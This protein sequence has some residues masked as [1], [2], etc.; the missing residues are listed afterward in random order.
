MSKLYDD[1]MSDRVAIMPPRWV[2][3]ADPDIIPK[4]R[5]LVKSLLKDATVFEIT[6]VSDYYWGGTSQEWFDPRTDFG[7]VRA[8]FSNFWME[9]R[10]P[11]RIRS[12]SGRNADPNR[13]PDRTG[14]LGYVLDMKSPGVMKFTARCVGTEQKVF[15]RETDAH[16]S[17]TFVVEKTD[18]EIVDAV[19]CL[20]LRSFVDRNGVVMGPMNH[21]YVWVRAD[22]SVIDY[23]TQIEVAPGHPG[24]FKD[25]TAGF[26]NLIHP[27]MMAID[28]MHARN[29]RIVD[30]Q[31]PPKLAKANLKRTGVPTVSWKTIVI[32]P[33]SERKLL[34]EDAQTQTGTGSRP[35]QIVPGHYAHYGVVGPGGW[36]RGKLFGRVSGRF[37]IPEH[38]AGNE[39]AGIVVKDYKMADPETEPPE[40]KTHRRKKHG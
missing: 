1:I 22:G 17:D 28:M 6:N 19:E 10:R 30:V 9:A 24:P 39:A 37:W 35:W 15:A 32:L 23:V 33:F 18:A 34:T 11:S 29:A 3:E 7:C 14:V 21:F 16:K 12:E 2:A 38:E 31:P 20:H 36:L 8:P 4:G 40:K 25:E 26:E 13:L 5:K 27:A